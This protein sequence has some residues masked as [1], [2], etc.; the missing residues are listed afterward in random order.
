MFSCK[1]VPLQELNVLPFI[2]MAANCFAWIIY[3]YIG[4]DWYIYFGNLP[5]VMFGMFYVLTCY[6]FSKEQVRA[7]H[8]AT[9]E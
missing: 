7:R 4:M 5:G 1:L 6:K 3:G 8:A 2:A 9:R